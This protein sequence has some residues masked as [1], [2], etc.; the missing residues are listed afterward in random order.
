MA[1]VKN[2]RHSLLAWL[3]RASDTTYVTH[4]IPT[5]IDEG[6]ARVLAGLSSCDEA[7]LE[8]VADGLAVA[9][10]RVLN[11]FA[12]RMASLAVR[13][14]NPDPVRRGLTAL[15]I[16][17]RAEDIREILLVL[18]LLHDAAI[19]VLGSAE[20]IFGE[21]SSAIGG[22]AF[23]RDFLER[24]EKDKRIEAMGYEESETAEGFLYVRTW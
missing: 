5:E 23:L 22:A 9:H 15:L 7:D 18:S 16:A 24:S 12:E 2:A 6:I 11:L 1:D 19:K 10:A 14:N 17:A 3:E 20:S 8:L 4:P 13:Q 21:V